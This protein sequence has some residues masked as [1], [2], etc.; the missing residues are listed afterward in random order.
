M[1]LKKAVSVS[2]IPFLRNAEN[3]RFLAQSASYCSVLFMVLP[4][5]VGSL[6]PGI[7]NCDTDPGEHWWTRSIQLIA[8]GGVSAFVTWLPSLFLIKCRRARAGYVS[9]LL[10]LALTLQ[11]AQVIFFRAF[12]TQIDERV[13]GLFQDNVSALWTF[14]RAEYHIDWLIVAAAVASIA[15]AWSIHSRRTWFPRFGVS[16]SAVT[17]L[18]VILAT[19]VSLALQ[20]NVDGASNY[21]S[22]KLA[23]APL[24]RVAKFARSVFLEKSTPDVVTLLTRTGDIE[25]GSTLAEVERR[26][27]TDPE[28]H[29]AQKV[30]RPAWLKRQPRN[31]FCFILESFEQDFINLPEMAT[32]AP[33]LRQFSSEGIGVSRMISASGATIDAVHSSMAGVTAQL[34]Y[35]GPRALEQYGLDTLP[36]MMERA[37]YHTAFY[38]G[39]HRRFGGKGDACEA[40]GF[41]S[42]TGCPD[43]APGLAANE[44]GVD[45]ASFFSWARE[46]IGPDMSGS[47][48]I[49]FLNVSNHP[50]FSAPEDR[51]WSDEEIPEDVVNRFVGA[52]RA[53]KCRYAK[54][55]RFADQ[56]LGKM[57]D[58]LNVA[59]PGSLFVFYGDH[60]GS[61]FRREKNFHVPFVLWGPEVLAEGVD[62]RE[63]FGAQMDIPATLAQL[64]LPEG[65]EFRSLGRPVWDSDPGRVSVGSGSVLCRMTPAGSD[66]PVIRLFDL[67]RAGNAAQDSP[68]LPIRL[69]G[70]A[71]RALSWSYLNDEPICDPRDEIVRDLAKLTAP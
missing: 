50:P 1:D 65:S 15:M 2:D 11:A 37:G 36:R 58:W 49:T 61:K 12:G 38:A 34:R 24:Y 56:E 51:L 53:E 21:S 47:R 9:M 44:W 60:C 70:S 13:F 5:L 52:D 30:T 59:Y 41:D 29:L 68:D 45:D 28:T 4:L 8:S 6:L 66:Q 32:M 22:A 31:V 23:E 69:K 39:S 63:W 54:H 57:V 27:G 67:L 43:V 17:V 48:F 71:I 25:A 42:F 55:V 10:P 35:P 62:T 64:I 26:L 7:L 19:T 46:Q 3:R 40:Y 18:L 14:A 20:L 16:T 33:R